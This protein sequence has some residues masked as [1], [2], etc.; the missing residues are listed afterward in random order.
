MNPFYRD[1]FGK[2]SIWGQKS[3][4]SSISSK[5]NDREWTNGG[6]GGAY[7]S[8]GRGPK[9]LFGEGLRYIF[10]SPEFSTP[11]CRSLTVVAAPIRQ[12][13]AKRNNI[14]IR[15]RVKNWPQN[16]PFWVRNWPFFLFF[17]N[18]PLSAGKTKFFK[19]KKNKN[20]Q[21]WP[22][23]E[24]KNWPIHVAQHRG[25]NIWLR[26]GQF[27]TREI[28]LFGPFLAFSK[29]MLKPHFYSVFGTNV[30][31]LS[32]PPKIRNTIS[33]HNCANW[34]N[35]PFF[36]FFAFWACPFLLFFFWEE[37]KIQNGKQNNKK[38]KQNHKMQ[39]R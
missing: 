26:Q 5:E 14:Q 11:L 30:H 28:S 4:F 15:C 2:S 38:R 34:K 10:H 27:L 29:D 7:H 8:W 13:N 18:H 16:Y 9:D 36:C 33:E 1:S 35:V 3:K 39:T 20:G 6:G 24:S 12:D 25:A 22:F 19:K 32:P 37:W 31:F 23:P 17:K 21:N